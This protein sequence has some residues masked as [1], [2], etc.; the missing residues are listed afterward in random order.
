M[1]K[2]EFLKKL[3]E[4][5]LATVSDDTIRDQINYY[6]NYISDEVDKGRSEKEVIEELGDPRLIAKTI[7]TVSNDSKPSTS[8][9]TSQSSNNYDDNS[10]N[11]DSSNGERKNSGR[12]YQAYVP[13]TGIIGCAIAMLVLFIIVMGLLRLFGHLA[14]GVGSL[15]LSGPIG[16]LLVVGLLILLFG[17]GR[18]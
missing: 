1:S 6:D 13:D 7:K 2:S 18:R 17:R 14:Y 15:A 5:L 10:Y 11:G 3:K 9:E 16:F 12:R 8:D 4:E